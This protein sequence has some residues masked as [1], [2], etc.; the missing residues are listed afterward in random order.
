MTVLEVD[1]GVVESKVHKL[2][3]PGVTYF[4]TVDKNLGK[5]SDDAGTFD[6]DVHE[7]IP[8]VEAGLVANHVH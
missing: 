3:E 6:G 8:S 7:M 5:E 2:G 4:R 1:R